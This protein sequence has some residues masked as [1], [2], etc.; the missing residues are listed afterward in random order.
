MRKFFLT[1]IFLIFCSICFAQ[2][3]QNDIPQNLKETANACVR[4]DDVNINITSKKDMVI[5]TKRIV[6]VFNESGMESINAVEHHDKSTRIKSMEAVIYNGSG[7]EIKKIKRKDFRETSVSQGSI[8][9]DNKAVY[10]DYT[11]I[12]YPFTV[13]YTSEIES[14]NTAFIPAWNPV[15]SYFE[16]IENAKITVRAAPDLGFKYKAFNIDGIANVQPTTDGVT[17]TLENFAARKSEEYSPYFR[18]FMPNVLF[19]LTSFHLEGVDGSAKT[20]DEF[21]SWIYNSLLQGTDELTV[22]TQAKIK[23][24]VGDEKDPIKIARIV[25]NFV[26]SKTRYISIQLGIGGWKPM[27]AKDVDRLGYGDCKALSNY[28]RALLKTVGVPSYYTIIYSGQRRDLQEDFVSMQGN[29]AI[30]ALPVG[31]KMYWLECTSQTDPFGYQGT[32]TDSRI[33]L[34]VK[35]EG[36]KII[37]T[38]EYRV[39]E[40]SQHSIGSFIINEEGNFSGTVSIKSKGT[41]YNNKAGNEMKSSDDASKFYK[42]YFGHINNLKINKLNFS[43]NKDDVEFSEEIAFEAV[44]YA[45]NVGGRM[46]VNVNAFNPIRSVPQRYRVRNNPFELSRGFYDYDEISIEIPIGYALEAKPDNVEVKEPFGV[47]KAEFEVVNPTKIIYKR[48]Y[49]SYAGSFDKNQYENFRKFREQVAR[50][51]NSKI[52]LVKNQ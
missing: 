38:H 43:N 25:Y 16:S 44:K 21:G 36:G 40:N 47:Y 52:V 4:W 35:P 15:K 17:I 26:Q 28:T 37:K 22:E 33:A 50:N 27:L 10:L 8:I 24:L 13:V 45:D 18:T 51:D 6:T 9:T 32:F 41:Q 14:S 46:L 1:P 48:T 2:N 31:E 3:F 23:A 34:L 5:T 39:D 19:G 29:H 12:A 49:Q 11:P 7:T 30:L 42:N 20:W